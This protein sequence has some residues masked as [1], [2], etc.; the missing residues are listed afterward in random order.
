[1]WILGQEFEKEQLY[2]SLA[3]GIQSFN[4][5]SVFLNFMKWVMV[6]L[7]VKNFPR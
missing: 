4:F 1:M 3:L 7:R 5:F 2:F 6:G